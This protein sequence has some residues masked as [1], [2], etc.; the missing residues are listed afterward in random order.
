VN[1]ITLLKKQIVR[2][3]CARPLVH[4]KQHFIER[5][6][7]MLIN[8]TI[9]TSMQ[10]QQ[11]GFTLIDLLVTLAVLAIVIAIGVPGLQTITESNRAASQNNL[12]PGTLMNSRLEAI[13]R[14]SDV[15]ICASTNPTAAV[16]V[17]DTNQWE[18]GWIVFADKDQDGVYTPGP[19]NDTLLGVSD[20]LSG[21]LTLRTV[22]FDDPNRVRIQANG[23]VRDLN[24]DGVSRGTFVM[25]TQDADPKKARAINVSNLG[26][27]SNALDTNSD[28]IVNDVN[29]NNVTCP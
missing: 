12:I 5:T 24:G 9:K 23:A 6:V 19:N 2:L 7:I 25:C 27:T 22:G 20:K 18:K 17:C 26:L 29:G 14:G 10:K 1:E 4:S 13:K 11:T 3:V 15:T 21:G 16:P 8:F 28:N